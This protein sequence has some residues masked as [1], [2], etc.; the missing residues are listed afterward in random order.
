MNEELIEIIKVLIEW[1][2]WTVVYGFI[3]MTVVFIIFYAF[4]N[5]YS[6]DLKGYK[7]L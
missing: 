4:I 6:V 1:G 3:T 7:D 2:F 5:I